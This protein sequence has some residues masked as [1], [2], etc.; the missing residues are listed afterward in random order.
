VQSTSSLA[1]KQHGLLTRAQALGYGLS[2][3]AIRARLDT[4]IWQRV[5]P[6]VYRVAGSRR[7]HE[8][9]VLAACL[10]AGG[11]VLAS[12]GTAARLHGLPAEDSHTHITVVGT[13]A[14]RVTGVEVHVVTG[15][16]GPDCAVKN[17]IPVT[18]VARTIIDLAQILSVVRLEEVLDHAL[19]ARLVSLNVLQQRLEKTGTR[20]RRGAGLLAVLI[21]VRLDGSPRP[22]QR[23]ERLFA[24]IVAEYGLPTPE[25]EVEFL[26]S[27]GRTVFV[28][29][30]FSRVVGVEIDSYTHHSS[31]TDWSADH[32]RNNLLRAKGLTLLNITY[33]MLKYD[34]AGVAA[35]V[36]EAL[37]SRGVL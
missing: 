20:G 11:K 2:D 14:P 27:D 34:R 7:T 16:Q 6:G 19:A 5:H 21:G 24:Q 28:D 37:V 13:K 12:H 26:L 36:D 8:Q 33:P 17:G 15:L 23:G 32:S 22:R 25:R 3:S 9:A 29:W 1:Q 35:T 10:A 30:V 31:L 4:G 18:T